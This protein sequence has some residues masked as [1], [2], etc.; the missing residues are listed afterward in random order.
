[1]TSDSRVLVNDLLLPE[2]AV[3][4]TDL[5]AIWMDW[6]VMQIGGKERTE[7]EFKD[8]FDQA[9]LEHVKTWTMEVSSFAVVEAKLKRV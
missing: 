2:R 3:P 8:L 1:M 4:G 5:T 9:G 6:A 7:K